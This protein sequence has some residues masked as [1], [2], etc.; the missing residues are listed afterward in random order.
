MRTGRELAVGP[1]A[2]LVAKAV[3]EQ[4]EGFIR[5]FEHRPPQAISPQQYA[6]LSEAEDRLEELGLKLSV[7]LDGTYRLQAAGTV[8]TMRIKSDAGELI[9]EVAPK[10]SSADVFRM[11]DRTS[12]IRMDDDESEIATAGLP[13]SAVFI[14]YF[15]RQVRAF[16]QSSNHRDYRFEEA[17]L[18]TGL[19]G[20]PMVRRYITKQIPSG[21]VA[22]MP[23]RYTT[24]SADVLANQIVA[25]SI[26]VANR[27]I[28][29][30]ALPVDHAIER[31]LQACRRSLLGVSPSR[32]T[33]REIANLRYT[34]ENRHFTRVHDL[35]RVL[36]ENQTI[37][38]EAGEHIPFQAF[39]LDM[40][41]LFQRYVAAIMK[42]AL[43][44]RFEGDRNKLRYP[45][46]LSGREIELDG[47]VATERRKVVVEAKYRAL[48]EDDG[49]LVLGAV[50]ERHVYQ[51]VAYAAH[52][53]VGAAA[54]VIVY[55]IDSSDERRSLRSQTPATNLSHAITDFGWART[56]P[57]GLQLYLMG[58]DLTSDYRRMVREVA[59]RLIPVIG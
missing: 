52:R 48:Q 35:C 9:V 14:A 27:V 45:T 5:V 51:T 55:P 17:M 31:D 21:R 28:R 37:A 42:D 10:I 24:R 7:D 3:E 46:D 20:R 43:G 36:L 25:H 2:A 39:S 23:C 57:S 34:R 32:I 11:I 15:A 1:E 47:L 50:P 13:A 4:G 19:R 26:E 22:E 12:P 8:G 33:P 30:L 44:H 54:A 58:I 56:S 6:V 59:D 53:D 18:S 40:P 29:G 16:L 38:M 41:S 49:D